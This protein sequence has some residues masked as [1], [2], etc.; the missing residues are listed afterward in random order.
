MLEPVLPDGTR[1]RFYGKAQRVVLER[2]LN[3][4]R[5]PSIDAVDRGD[6]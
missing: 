1:V 2:I 3:P 5:D 6:V 4:Y